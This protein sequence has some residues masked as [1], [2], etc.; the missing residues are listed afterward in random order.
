VEEC[1]TPPYATR[2][3]SEAAR[4]HSFRLLR[5]KLLQSRVMGRSHSAPAGSEP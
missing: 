3:R 4:E 1:L 5:R 2:R